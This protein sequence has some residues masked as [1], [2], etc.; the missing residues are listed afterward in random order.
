MYYK[1]KHLEELKIVSSYF[2]GKHCYRLWGICMFSLSLN[3]FSV[4][5]PNATTTKNIKV[6]LPLTM[7]PR[8]SISFADCYSEEGGS[9]GTVHH[10]VI[11]RQ[12]KHNLHLRLQVHEWH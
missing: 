3:E 9:N 8:Q 2:R 12:K 10:K 7:M 5:D 4:G 11:S 6:Y 1:K